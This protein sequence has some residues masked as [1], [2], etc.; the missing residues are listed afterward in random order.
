MALTEYSTSSAPA[1]QLGLDRLQ[2]GV[3]RAIAIALGAVHSTP[4]AANTTAACGRSPVS[5]CWRQADQAVVLLLAGHAL[6]TD[7][8]DD[9]LVEDLALAVGQV[10]EAGEGGVDVGLAL[11]LDAQFLQALP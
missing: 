7:Q 8:G 9:V 1:C 4:P 5:E 10:L 6:V 3:H 11:H 2:A